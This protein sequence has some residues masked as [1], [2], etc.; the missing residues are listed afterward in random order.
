M[1]GMKDMDMNQERYYAQS[2]EGVKSFMYRVFGWMAFALTLSAGTA[3]YVA[4]SPALLNAVVKNPWLVFGLI[5][6]QFALVIG[7]SAAITRLTPT[8]AFIMFA[9]YAGLTGITLSPIFIVYTGASIV[10]TFLVAAGMFGAMAVYGAVTRADL[11]GMG[12]FMYMALF[13]LIIA[14]LVN[15]FLRSEGFNLVIAMFGVVVFAGLTAFDI[16]K[17]KEF[18]SRFDTDNPLGA[19]I[20][21]L[22]ALQLY[23]DFLNLFLYLLQIMGER[24]DK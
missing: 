2:Y 1:K 19:N 6:V 11:T 9:V 18:A 24:R 16:Q 21:L 15:M 17:L 23:L 4:S 12:T 10:S 5:I 14:Q 7:L 22:G 20:A 3:Y 13:G 8:A